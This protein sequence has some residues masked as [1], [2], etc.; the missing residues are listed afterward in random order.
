MRASA[1][2]VL[3]CCLFLIGC[4]SDFVPPSFPTT[5]QMAEPLG[6]VMD[7][8]VSLPQLFVPV[9]QASGLKLILRLE[10]EAA[11]FGQHEARYIIEDALADM[12]LMVDVEDLGTG[13]TTITVT[14]DRWLTTRIG[15]LRIGGALFELLLEGTPEKGGRFVSGNAWESQ[16]ALNGTFNG[17]ARH[18]FLVATTD[19]SAAGRITEVSLV[20]EGEIRVRANLT[21]VSPDPF[22]RRSGRGV[23][24]MNRLTFDNLQRLDP[25]AD[26]ATSWQSGVGVGA[27]PH[28]AVLLDDGRM[29]VTRYEPP[30]NDL[31]I[32]DASN[33]RL[34][35][36]VPL[37]GLAE[38][39]DG[40]PR[41]DH[42]VKINNIVFVGLQDLDR[43]F[44]RFAEGKLA[45]VDPMQDS[46]VGVIPLGGRN[47]G[48]MEVVVA[49]D[50]TARL[51]VALAGIFAGLQ[52][53]ELSGGVMVVDPVNRVLERMALDDDAAGGNIGAL[54]MVSDVLGYVVSSDAAFIN[55]VLAFDPVS[56]SIRRI[57]L[58]TNLFVP[59]LEVD[60]GGVLAV[61]D[62]SFS[63]PRLCLY[64]V[65]ADPAS[66]ET[67]LGCADLDLAPLSLEALD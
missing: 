67:E 53:Q 25:D 57:L 28:D 60:S 59:E 35:G 2:T 39:P 8:D 7:V 42:L 3:L 13:V 52:P 31:A 47:P 45:V 61:P 12:N 21:P 27:N 50:G 18:R 1:V 36:T 48:A 58:E 44:T 11:G 29:L 24:V 20:R 66:P 9:A 65:A 30:F 56:G 19:L 55:R 64:R 38:N 22:L 46:V 51:Y 4:G 49:S 40:T 33:G 5:G 17:W 14:P 43:T 16:T 63:R 41:A 62:T 15:P 10:I 34:L 23:F 6:Q 54:A 37:A 26:F 32:L